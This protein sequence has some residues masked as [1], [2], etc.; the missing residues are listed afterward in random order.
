[1]RIHLQ[2][3]QLLAFLFALAPTE[4]A[5]NLPQ[6]MLEELGIEEASGVAHNLVD[7]QAEQKPAPD[8]QEACFHLYSF[9]V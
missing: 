3:S 2:S 4:V 9:N 6:N 1:M 5:S 8:P 7:Y